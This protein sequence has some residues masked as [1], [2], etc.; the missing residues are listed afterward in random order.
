MTPEKEFTAQTT[1][2]PTLLASETAFAFEFLQ[3]A[4][5]QDAE[6]NPIVG[7]P[8]KEPEWSPESHLGG[9]NHYQLKE[10]KCLLPKLFIKQ[11]AC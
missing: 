3:L 11:T 5:S 8:C 6:F 1:V 9:S 7:N 4:P 10:S 2:S